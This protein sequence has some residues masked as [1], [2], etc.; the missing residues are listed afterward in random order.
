MKS[1]PDTFLLIF[2]IIFSLSLCGLTFGVFAIT[3]GFDAL[4]LAAVIFVG[5]PAML[6]AG[7]LSLRRNKVD[8]T[9]LNTE[10]RANKST[11]IDF[12]GAEN[13][14]HQAPSFANYQQLKSL[15]A[16]HQAQYSRAK[17]SKIDQSSTVSDQRSGHCQA[18]P[19]L[20]D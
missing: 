16:A 13:S 1:T 7:W 3:S 18:S 6:S 4:W 12:A 11:T 8:A 2:L 20:E 14:P 15:M 17:Y 10:K 5:F 19:Y 9:S